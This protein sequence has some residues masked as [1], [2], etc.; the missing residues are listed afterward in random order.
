MGIKVDFL[1]LVDHGI[2][3]PSFEVLEQNAG[4]LDL[5][6]R[7]LFDFRTAVTVDTPRPPPSVAGR[8]PTAEKRN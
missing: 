6:E 3:A 7:E 2:N 4:R 8:F 5:E 1:N